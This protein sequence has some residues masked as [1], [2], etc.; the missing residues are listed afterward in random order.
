MT[1]PNGS[2]KQAEREAIQLDAL[3]A[4][5]TYR[6]MA[7]VNGV[8]DTTRDAREEWRQRVRMLERRRDHYCE[9]WSV[10]VPHERLFRRNSPV[11]PEWLQAIVDAF[12]TIVWQLD[13]EF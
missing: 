4:A 8:T 2:Q 13:H 7:R 6:A 10:N 3:Q 1:Q 12:D 11:A 5:R 9:T